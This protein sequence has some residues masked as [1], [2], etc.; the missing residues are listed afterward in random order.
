MRIQGK[1]APGLSAC[2]SGACTVWAE[3]R[4]LEFSYQQVSSQPQPPAHLRGPLLLAQGTTVNP[5][6]QD[7]TRECK[8]RWPLQLR[9]CHRELPPSASS[10]TWLK[11][12]QDKNTW[13]GHV[14]E[15]LHT[16]LP[17]FTF[18]GCFLSQHFAYLKIRTV[19]NFKHS[20]YRREHL[21]TQVGKLMLNGY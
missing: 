17:M 8:M 19:W 10:L 3:P 1:P 18:L 6:L 5:C 2:P 15:I 11:D 9:S 14:T 7:L 13:L 16:S 4:S 21:V 12:S 20:D